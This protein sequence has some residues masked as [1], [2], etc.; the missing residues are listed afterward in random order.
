[1]T[2][3]TCKTQKQPLIWH[4]YSWIVLKTSIFC[5]SWFFIHSISQLLYN[6]EF[7]FFL[8]PVQIK[9]PLCKDMLFW[10]LHI[11]T[12]IHSWWL[13]RCHH[14]TTMCTLKATI[15]VLSKFCG[16][17]SLTHV[18]LTW[19]KATNPTQWGLPTTVSVTSFTQC[20]TE[21]RW[22]QLTW[23]LIHNGILFIP[24]R[25]YA[26]LLFLRLDLH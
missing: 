4:S 11:S 12:L 2:K 7:P 20:H 19:T 3:L 5:T 24:H 10:R 9:S 15:P 18:R 17:P 22:I 13:Y 8:T 21:I 26:H 16:A 1:M 6:H 14:Y 23:H 25:T